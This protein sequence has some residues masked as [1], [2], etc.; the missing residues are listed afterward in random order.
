MRRFNKKKPVIQKYSF[1]ASKIMYSS[2]SL[3]RYRMVSSIL[4]RVS[5]SCS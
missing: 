5:P 1:T 2:S 3:A 4:V